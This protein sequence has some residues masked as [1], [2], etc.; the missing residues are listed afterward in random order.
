MYWLDHP[1]NKCND[2]RKKMGKK[3]M[4]KTVRHDLRNVNA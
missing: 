4:Y 1:F 3:E 2:K